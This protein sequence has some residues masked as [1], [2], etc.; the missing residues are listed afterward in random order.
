MTLREWRVEDVPNIVALEKIC[1][2]DAWTEEEIQSCL[3]FP[4]YKT[5]LLE[6]DGELVGY[7]CETVLFEDAEILNIAITPKYRKKGYGKKL[8][9]EMLIAAKKLGAEQA[10]LEVRESNSSAK[11]LYVAFGFEQM[12]LR[13]GYYPDGEDAIVMTKKL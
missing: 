8:L 1:F 5:F 2:S 13:K 3:R 9:T 6:L 11:G 4:L 12:G 10:F 7:A